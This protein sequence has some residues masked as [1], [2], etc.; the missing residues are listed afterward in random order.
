MHLTSFHLPGFVWYGGLEIH[1][2]Y[3]RYVEPTSKTYS[4]IQYAEIQNYLLAYGSVGPTD[5]DP[6]GSQHWERVP[7]LMFLFIGNFKMRP[8]D[9]GG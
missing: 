6:Y 7:S 4:I 1:W 9:T 3:L 2:S 8:R 5:H